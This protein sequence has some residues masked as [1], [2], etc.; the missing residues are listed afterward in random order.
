MR[1]LHVTG[2]FALLLLLAT[3]FAACRTPGDRAPAVDPATLVG[4]YQPLEA[5]GGIVALELLE[6]G[7]FEALALPNMG[8]DGCA[9]VE[10]N[11]VS[12]GT[13]VLEGDVI[14]LRVEHETPG[15]AL[16]LTGARAVLTD[17]GFELWRGPERAAFEALGPSPY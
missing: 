6:D 10:G 14:Q 9:T 12:Q 16:T 5:A 15:L 7:T 13:W 11:G 17:E 3:A 8:P 2:V 1:A 4:N